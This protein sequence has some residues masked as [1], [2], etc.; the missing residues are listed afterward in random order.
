MF[1]QPVIHHRLDL[2][3]SEVFLNLIDSVGYDFARCVSW[4]R[5]NKHNVKS[6]A[7]GYSANNMPLLQTLKSFFEA[8]LALES[9]DLDPNIFGAEV[10]A[11]LTAHT[12]KEHLRGFWEPEL[13]V[14]NLLVSRV[15]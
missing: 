11:E 15:A 4:T 3:I 14:A 13:H 1:H 6:G 8:R 2:K 5:M 9:P 12:E 10:S 7:L